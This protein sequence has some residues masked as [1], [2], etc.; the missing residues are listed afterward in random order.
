MPAL[1]LAIDAALHVGGVVTALFVF[2]A[3]RRDGWRNP[4]A[5]SIQLP[6]YT[7]VLPLVLFPVAYYLLTSASLRLASVDP[8]DSATPGSSSWHVVQAVD[9]GVRLVLSFAVLA[10]FAPI[11]CGGGAWHIGVALRVGA[12][13]AIAAIP[14]C[15]VQLAAGERVWAL[16]QPST[17]PPVHPILQAMDLSAWGALG[18]A[19]LIVAAVLIAPLAEEVFFRG[20]LLGMIRRAIGLPWAAIVVTSVGFGLVHVTQPQDVV[21]LVSLGLVLGYVRV[22]YDSLLACVVAHSL[23]NARTI[24]L[25]LLDGTGVA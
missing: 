2:R 24:G 19:Q 14:L 1:A 8:A 16:F 21:P 6:T 13:A 12:L 18:R 20:L 7:S 25:L 11:A 10:W 23:F 4:L 3:F 22:R 9:A 17:E 5:A 15:I